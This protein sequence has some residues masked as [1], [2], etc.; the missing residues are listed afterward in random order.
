MHGWPL[1]TS[2]LQLRHVVQADALEMMALNA[3]P[4][5]RQWLPSHVYA[6]G[7]PSAMPTNPRALHGRPTGEA[8]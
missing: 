5:T 6:S 1:S 8:R 3:E 2:S 4:S 7:V